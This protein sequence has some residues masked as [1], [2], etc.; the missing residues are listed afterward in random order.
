MWEDEAGEV[1]VCPAVP[2]WGGSEQ[3]DAHEGT[4]IWSVQQYLTTLILGPNAFVV[5]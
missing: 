3:H 2:A 5:K 4:C 1:H